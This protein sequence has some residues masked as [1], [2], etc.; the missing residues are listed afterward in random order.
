[1]L[2]VTTVSFFALLAIRP[3]IVRPSV[4]R[5]SAQRTVQ[6]DVTI[7][8]D[9][10]RCQWA[11]PPLVPTA[12]RYRPPTMGFTDIYAAWSAD[13]ADMMVGIGSVRRCLRE[14]KHVLPLLKEISSHDFFSYYAV[15]LITPCMYFPTEESTCELDRCHIESVDERNLPPELLRRDLSEYGFTID[16][17]CRKDMPSDFTEYFDLRRCRSRDTGYDGSRVWRFIHSKICFTKFLEQPGYEWKRDYNRAVSGMH[18]AVHAEIISDLGP[19]PEGRAEYRRRLRDQPGAITNLY[20]AY[21][22]TLCALHDSRARLDS[23]NF[24]E[25]SKE[26]PIRALVRQLTSSELLRDG[27]VQRAATNFRAHAESPQAEVWRMRM[28]HRDLKQIMGCVDCNLCRV[29]GTVMTLGLGATLQVLLGSD[30]RGGDPLALDR[31]QLAALVTTA[32]KFGAACE[33]VELFTELDIE[34]DRRAAWMARSWAPAFGPHR[35]SEEEERRLALANE[36]KRAWLAKLDT[37]RWGASPASAAEAEAEAGAGAGAGA[38]TSD[39]SAPTSAARSAWLAPDEGCALPA[40]PEEVECDVVVVGGGPAGCTCALY[41]S[42][43]NLHTVVLD[44]NAELGALAITSQIANYPG[45]DTTVSGDELLGK[46]RHQA[47]EHGTDYRR[48]QVYLV[49]VDGERKRVYTPE[50]TYHARAVVLATGAMGRPPSFRGEAELLGKGVSYC[51]TCDGAFYCDREVAVVGTNRAA[52]DE[53]EILTRFAS[54]VHWITRS[55]PRDDDAHA[56]ALLARPNVRHWSRAK[57][58]GIEGGESGVTGIRLRPTP[59]EAA[60]AKEGHLLAVEGVFIYGPGSKPITDFLED[61]V[62]CKADGGVLV[63]EDMAT[64]VPGVYA[65]GDIT[66]RPHKQAVNAASDGCVAAMSVEKYLNGRKNL[67]VDWYHKGAP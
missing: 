27:A 45:V 48:S 28:R 49:D 54:T 4:Q 35:K 66:N 41:T 42:R 51:A 18:S 19:T 52:V 29:H 23:C 36:A 64:N 1:M 58:E 38:P 2:L 21:M 40:E 5:L 56:R 61:K 22:L 8:V 24:F 44:K 20:F 11:P 30:G 16:G 67:R 26:Q 34:D 55:D 63:D 39:A 31:V 62:L 7:T 53:A 37:P 47:I 15:N 25:E 50:A 10:L 60:E 17:W 32:A 6:R 13:H 43:A 57:V 14:T 46:M 12:R 9:E 3:R 33:T 59:G 65:V